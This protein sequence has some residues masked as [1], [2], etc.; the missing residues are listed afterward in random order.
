M[1]KIKGILLSAILILS[2]L[3]LFACKDTN[4]SVD[5]ISF[6]EQTIELL[7]GEEYSPQIKILPSYATNRSYTLISEDETALSVEGGTIKAIKAGVGIKLK[8]VSNG[9]AKFNDIISVNIYNEAEELNCPKNL[10]FDG[11]KFYFDAVDNASTYILNIDGKQINIGNNTEY[12]FENLANKISGDIFNQTLECSVMAVGDGKIHKNSQYSDAVKFIKISEV[13]NF[14]IQNNV[15]YLDALS[16][17]AK[18]NIS[19]TNSI[20][21]VNFTITNDEFELTQLSYSLD[22]FDFAEGEDYNVSVDID[23]DGYNASED[24]KICKPIIKTIVYKVVGKVKNVALNNYVLSWDL[25]DNAQ[26]YKVNLYKDDTL[27]NTFE[28]VQTNCITLN[29]SEGG[30]YSCEVLGE[31]GKTINVKPSKVFSDKLTFKVLDAPT[32]VIENNSVKWNEVEGTEGYL[33]NIYNSLGDAIIFDKFVSNT[34]VD[35]SKYGAGKYTIKLSS[36]GNN[37]DVLSSKQTSTDSW[38]ILNGLSGLTIQD[39]KLYWTDS[40]NSSLSKYRLTINVNLTENVDITLTNDD[41][42]SQYTFNET[43]NQYIYDLSSYNFDEGTHNITVQSLGE[44]KT[45]DSSISLTQVVKLENS[46]ISDLTNNIF[47]IE[48]VLNATKYEIKIYNYSDTSYSSPIISTEVTDGKYELDSSILNAGQYKVKIFVYGNNGNIF[49]ADNDGSIFEFKKLAIPELSVDSVNM[50][51]NMQQDIVDAIRYELFENNKLVD[52]QNETYNLSNLSAGEYVYTAKAIGNGK[53]I[54][55]SNITALNDAIKVKKL[56]APSVEFDNSTLVYTIT[57]EDSDFVEKYQFLLNDT[58]MVVVNNKVD[59]SSVI[60]TNGEYTVKLIANPIVSSEYDLIIKS[61]QTEY[62]VNKLNGECSA[63]VVGG[64]LVITPI[65]TLTSGEYEL[66]LRIVDDKGNELTLNNIQY[67]NSRFLIPIYDKNYDVIDLKNDNDVQFFTNAGKYTLYTTIYKLNDNVVAS[68]EVLCANNITILDEVD[69]ISRSAQNIQFNNIENANSYIVFVELNSTTWYIDISGKYEGESVNY[70]PMASLVELMAQNGVPYQE[71][72]VY[73]IGFVSVASNGEYVSNK[74]TTTYSFEFLPVP[75]ISVTENDN[76]KF[77][78]ITNDI[79]NA[80]RYSIDFVQESNNKNLIVAKEGENYVYDLANLTDGGFVAGNI[81]IKV[82]AIADS[83]NYFESNYSTCSIVKLAS[84]SLRII[85][86]VITWNEVL[87]AKQYNLHYIRFGVDKSITLY[88]GVEG[89]NINSGNCSYVFNELEEGTVEM[90]LQVD[91]VLENN[92][93]FYINSNAGEHFVN[94]YK[95]AKPV[96]NVV[97][98]ELHIEI[99]NTDLQLSSDIEVLLDGEV[100]NLNILTSTE[101][102]TINY[103]E[104]KTEIIINPNIVLQYVSTDVLT[105]EKLSIKLYSVDSKTINSSYIE[106]DLFGLINPINLDVTTSTTKI[107][108]TETIDEV[109]EKLSWDNPSV[110]EEYVAKYE[111]II[112]YLEQDYKFESIT[113]VFIMPK[114]YDE[115]S[116]GLLDE[117]EIEF[118]AGVYTIKVKAITD[119]NN[120]VVN[121]KYSESIQVTVLETPTNLAT[122]AGNFVW[123]GDVSSESYLIRVYLLNGE[124]KELIVSSETTSTEFDMCKLEPFETGVYGVTVQ[125]MHSHNKILASKESEVFEVIRLP[126]ATGYYVKNGVFYIKVHKFFDMAEVYLTDTATNTKKLTFTFINSDLSSYKEYVSSITNWN[127]SDVINGYEQDDNY[128]S[129]PYMANNDYTLRQALAEGYSVGIKL[130]GNTCNGVGAIISGHT[131]TNAQNLNYE[132]DDVIK[133]STPIVK[134]SE[135]VRGQFELSLNKSLKY[136][137]LQYYVDAESGASLQGVH[138]YEVNVSADKSYNMLVAEIVDQTKFDASATIIQED[139]TKNYIK[140]F[141]YAG[142]YFNI[143][144][145]LYLNFSTD[146]YYYYSSVGV[147]SSINLVE[148][149]SFIVNARLLGDDTHFVQSNLSANA[150]VKRYSVLNMEMDNGLLKWANQGDSLDEPIYVVSL[151]DSLGT[152]YELVLYNSNK[153]NEEQIKNLIETDESKNYIYDTINYEINDEFI[154]YD[155][156]A[157]VAYNYFGSNGI[158]LTANIMTYFTDNTNNNKLL[159]QSTIPKTITILPINNISAQAGILNWNLSYVEK[160][161]GG[162]YIDRYEFIIYDENNEKLYSTT[163]TGSDYLIKQNVAYYEL[164]S[165]YGVGGFAFEAGKNYKFSI[166]ALAGDSITYVNSILSTTNSIYLL[167]TLTDVKMSNGVVTWTNPTNNAVEVCITYQLDGTYVTY[168]TIINESTFDLPKNFVL[169]ENGI[170]RQFISGYDYSI[171]VRLR[172]G[173]TSLNGFYSDIITTQRLQSVTQSSISTN[174]GILT[175]GEIGI[176]G[177]SYILNY[178]L[179]DGTKSSAEVSTNSFNFAGLLDGE[180]IVNIYA[181]HKDYF[182][183]F[184]SEDKTLFKLSVPSN[185]QLVEETTIITWDKVIDDNN[186]EINDYIVRIKVGTANPIE[187]YCNSNSWSIVDVGA[188]EFSFAVCA[189]SSEIEGNLINGEYSAYIQ[190]SQPESVDGT[191]FIY[192]ESK[193]RFEWKAINDEQAEDKYYIGYNYS[194]AD[195]Q[196]SSENEVL[197]VAHEIV[198]EDKYYYYY[199][200]VIG[201][202]RQVYIRV[203]RVSSLASNNTYWANESGEN[204]SLTFNLFNSGDGSKE[205][206]YQIY[207][208]THLRNIKYFPSAYYQI[209]SDITLTSS[210]PITGADVE[211]SGNLTTV[212]EFYIYNYSVGGEDSLLPVTYIGLINKAKGATFNNIKIS[213]LNI[214][215]YVNSTNLYVGGLVAYAEDSTFNNVKITNGTIRIL[216]NSEDGEIGYTNPICTINVGGIIGCANNCVVESCEI[217][218]V[219]NTEEF[220]NIYIQL[221]GNSNTLAYVGGIVGQAIGGTYSNNIAIFNMRYSLTK[222]SQLLPQIKVGVILGSSNGAILNEIEG[223]EN[224]GTCYLYDANGESQEITELIAT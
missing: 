25:V 88:E 21:N 74:G 116:N 50:T 223:Q 137:S 203:V 119:N 133:L 99:S 117:D 68:N 44:S 31:T 134:I 26:Y 55:D 67:Q 57:C 37:V 147:Y 182:S 201:V 101:D 224:S 127:N 109:I 132:S 53:E 90:Y 98:G 197:V 56:I 87:N 198:G 49:D 164:P 106:K 196:S 191:T 211:F 193:Q 41:L 131:L 150:I 105:S 188:N 28:E 113:N 32:I 176:K 171:K 47:L 178:T 172:G 205:N 43:S 54:L 174:S 209:L 151:N 7:V 199:P 76:N 204:Y 110:N 79:E 157:R 214:S 169:D 34:T 129:I 112:N 16:N 29:L 81:Q 183:S 141:V 184:S 136:T 180:M 66:T 130:I 185:I 168:V 85:N 52:L 93:I 9:N 120:N 91:S 24:V 33:L 96:I 8:V 153:Y 221:E 206:P 212:G 35:V 155:G 219:N 107:E 62:V 142:K 190:I 138:L 149:G 75:T 175:W 40:D 216:K 118:G 23:T 139:E 100:L 78:S 173:T 72:V 82:K 13:S 60:T 39:K 114:F 86:G 156:L 84:S 2:G 19:I 36:C 97:N 208:E 111:I 10:T 170:S 70:L 65:N 122:N 64:N 210:E 11:N 92:G 186:E 181:K 5:S 94:A 123:T 126:Q 215:G 103:Y 3:I 80:S 154:T 187:Y 17:V 22:E 177:V 124:N 51:V 14:Y 77:L 6:T 83:G 192:N 121:S 207:N 159:A 102:I 167:P 73:T 15:L 161:G 144:D 165:R 158:T 195:S 189:I 61:E 1:K 220:R 166:K 42:N 135:T 140:Y 46:S 125:A 179:S 38:T 30:N 69:A 12:L 200:Y 71:E 163:L 148:G 108:G 104:T 59:A 152:K 95:L 128:I 217:N 4:V 27:L 45:F 194:T 63:E 143:I 89:F 162:E 218:W 145:N 58:E 20:S 18:Y 202:Y 48:N 222:I 160:S 115:N 213:N 146:Y